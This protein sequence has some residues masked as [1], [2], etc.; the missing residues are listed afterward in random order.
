MGSH[1][2][3]WAPIDS[4]GFPSHH[5]GSH[6]FRWSPIARHGLQC[7]PWDSV[8]PD[9][10]L[11]V[12]TFTSLLFGLGLLNCKIAQP[13]LKVFEFGICGRVVF[14][15]RICKR[16]TCLYAPCRSLSSSKTRLARP[17]AKLRHLWFL[18]SHLCCL[19]STSLVCGLSMCLAQ[20]LSS[21]IS[22]LRNQSQSSCTM[23]SINWLDVQ[24]LY[25]SVRFSQADS[26]KSGRRA[27]VLQALL[28]AYLPSANSLYIYAGLNQDM[29]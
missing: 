18:L 19:G 3:P 17:F 21:C 10:I 22:Q 24:R 1:S 26:G 16:D 12:W 9:Q 28:S 15:M 25:F 7:S 5:M 20:C 6:G 23:A 27:S 8:A 11:L 2:I 13:Y 4:F 29:R 14:L